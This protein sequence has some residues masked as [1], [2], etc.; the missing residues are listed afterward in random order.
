LYRRLLQEVDLSVLV[1]EKVVYQRTDRFRQDHTFA[2]NAS[3]LERAYSRAMLRS[4]ANAI[5]ENWVN[6]R[7]REMSDRKILPAPHRNWNG[8]PR[9]NSIPR[10]DGART[11][12][13][14]PTRVLN[15]SP[16]AARLRADCLCFSSRPLRIKATDTTPEAFLVGQQQREPS[17]VSLA[18]AEL[19]LFDEATS[20]AGARA[21]GEVL[22][23]IPIWRATRDD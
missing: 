20:G 13:L 1:G 5:G 22:N 14:G 21:I 12:G 11:S 9:F 4:G 7:W 16:R 17:P 19:M 8:V 3:P 15:Y 6:A 2:A 10:P 23:T 18:R